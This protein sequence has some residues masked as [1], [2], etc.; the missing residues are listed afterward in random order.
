MTTTTITKT[1]RQIVD[2]WKDTAL[3]GMVSPYERDRLIWRWFDGFSTGPT[4]YLLA[5]PKDAGLGLLR[6]C[7]DLAREV[8]ALPIEQS[9][10][11]VYWGDIESDLR[12]PPVL[13]VVMG[14][15]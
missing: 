4:L 3:N 14:S 1:D 7:R 2:E 13:M 11:K 10:I 5:D 8:K 6:L 9:E 15:K 12:T